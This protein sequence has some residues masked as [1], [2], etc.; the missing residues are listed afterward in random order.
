ML[1][2]PPSCSYAYDT[3]FTVLVWKKADHTWL[4]W[5]IDIPRPL[6]NDLWI[7]FFHFKSKGWFGTGTSLRWK[8]LFKLL[9]FRYCHT[10]L[11][12][13]VGYT[14]KAD[15][16]GRTLRCEFEPRIINIYFI[17]ML[18]PSR[19]FLVLELLNAVFLVFLVFMFYFLLLYFFYFQSSSHFC[20]C[21]SLVD[22]RR[23]QSNLLG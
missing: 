19:I 23:W 10:I 18:L 2:P 17:N 15:T 20:F 9:L 6:T 3:G 21:W 8:L 14:Q 1:P 5:P 11:S 13:A 7:R 16:W 4:P 12:G 22:Q